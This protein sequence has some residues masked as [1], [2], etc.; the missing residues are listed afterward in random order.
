[1]GGRNEQVSLRSRNN[2]CQV[3][4]VLSKQRIGRDTVVSKPDPNMYVNNE[5]DTN[6]DTC[7]LGMN[8]IPITYTNC[9]ADVYPYSNSY[10]PLENVPI[11][12]RA[13]SYYHPNG[14]TYILIFH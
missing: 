4:N 6:Y 10:E 13:T 7:C 3:Q 12:S 8:F 9:T 2:N 1:M 5:A 11:V 14:N